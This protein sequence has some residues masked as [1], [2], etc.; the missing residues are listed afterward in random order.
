MGPKFP[1]ILFTKQNVWIFKTKFF[2]IKAPHTSCEKKMPL[3]M[4]HYYNA[5][6]KSV[7]KSNCLDA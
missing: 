7:S 5:L 3:Q 1:L 6:S 2:H 4:H